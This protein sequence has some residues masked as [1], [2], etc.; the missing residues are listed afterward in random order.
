[1]SLT[2]IETLL[3]DSGDSVRREVLT[4]LRRKYQIPLH[5]LEAEWNTTAETI[6]EA[7]ANASDL[8][9]RGIRGVLAEAVFRRQVLPSSLPRWR[10]LPVQGDQAYDLLLDDGNGALRIQVKLQRKEKGGIKFHRNSQEFF[11]VETQRTRTGKRRDQEDSR[12]YRVS[13]FDIIA[14]CLH[15]STNDWGR[16]IYCGTQDLLTRPNAPHLLEVMQP[17]PVNGSVM[18]ST[19]FDYIASRARE[20]RAPPP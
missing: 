5:P 20:N 2:Q 15:P 18:W 19:N 4:I 13:E 10:E 11:V 3:D 8:T 17:V 14:V 7:I 16:F 9:Q 12:P 6:L 1:M